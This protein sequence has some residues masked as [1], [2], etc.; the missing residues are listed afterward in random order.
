M[1][2]FFLILM[3]ALLPLRSWA[4]DIMAMEMA[5][6]HLNA[7]TL[8]AETTDDTWVNGH[9]GSQTSAETA[10]STAD[11]PGHVAMA[12]Q[13]SPGAVDAVDSAPNGHCSTCGVCQI[14]HTV[15]L[16]SATLWLA[17]SFATSSLLP[18]GS[19]RFTS[20]LPALGLKPPI[21]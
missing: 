7:I 18:F 14:C 15:A 8:I 13:E 2:H 11:C 19:S 10:R 12:P 16:A 5:S 17:Q 1:R 3:I 4:G 9:F 6:Q 21:S 20:A